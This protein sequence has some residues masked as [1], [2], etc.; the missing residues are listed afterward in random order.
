[1]SVP[2][3]KFTCSIQ[4]DDCPPYCN[5]I[6]RP[7]DLSYTVW[8]YPGVH[9]HLPTLLPDP[10][11]PPPRSGWFHLN[12]SGSNIQS[13][14]F[15]PYLN[16]TR[17]ID[18]SKSRIHSISDT[19][20]RVLSEIDYVDLSGNQLTSL[21]TFLGSENITF[22]WLSLHDNPLRCNC[23]DKWIRD[24]LQ[25][26]DGGL[27]APCNRARAVCGSPGWLRN[28]SVLG[29]TDEDF[30]TD[31]SGERTQLIIEVCECLK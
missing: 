23:E 4:S 22:R 9:D 10:D 1:V 7:S 20:W 21:P 14:E 3:E 25:S 8:C 13:L 16:R 11:Y 17:S 18:V 30:C 28:R 31:P 12:F 19:M 24:W 6:K 15:R 5:C 29:M 2:L 26:L 27:F